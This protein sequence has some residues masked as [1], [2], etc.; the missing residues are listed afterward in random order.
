MKILSFISILISLSGFSQSNVDPIY[1]QPATELEEVVVFGE[2]KVK[3][4][5]LGFLKKEN[6]TFSLYKDYEIGVFVPNVEGFKTIENLYLNIDNELLATCEIQLN[7]YKF[8]KAPTELIISMKAIID[9]SNKKKLII[10]TD[11]L[12]ISFPR[13]G[14]FISTKVLSNLK[15]EDES[16]LR[17]YLTEKYN[18]QST[19]I[20]GSIY[21]NDWSSLSKLNIGIVRSKFVNACYGFFATK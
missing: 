18:S 3:T 9:P 2:K 14:I 8:D 21:G 12:I 13:D 7:F 6:F 15:E 16:H 19:F 5:Q 20:R 10:S 17:I 11:N 4:T 1:I